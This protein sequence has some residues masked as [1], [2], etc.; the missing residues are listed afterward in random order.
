MTAK[1]N[2]MSRYSCPHSHNCKDKLQ[3]EMVGFLKC[4]YRFSF[5]DSFRKENPPEKQNVTGR[6]QTIKWEFSLLTPEAKTVSPFVPS[7][8]DTCN[9]GKGENWFFFFLKIHLETKQNILP[10]DAELFEPRVGVKQISSLVLGQAACA[11]PRMALLLWLLQQWTWLRD[12]LFQECTAGAV[13]DLCGA[14]GLLWK[15]SEVQL[16]L[17]QQWSC[18]WCWWNQESMS[19]WEEWRLYLHLSRGFV[20]ISVVYCFLRLVISDQGKKR[21]IF[22]CGK[23]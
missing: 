23:L 19:G 18:Y 14:A 7:G 8:F 6:S 20:F 22:K 12:W 2:A 15:T 3:Y 10:W 21:I 5:G 9:W 16:W 1:C 11:P 4:I 13:S 17:H